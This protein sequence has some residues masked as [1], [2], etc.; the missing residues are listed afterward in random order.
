[1]YL[2]YVY[3]VLSGKISPFIEL[4]HRIKKVNTEYNSELLFG[5]NQS[6][7]QSDSQKHLCAFGLKNFSKHGTV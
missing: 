6:R 1:M 4:E 2:E 5:E 3:Y 7:N